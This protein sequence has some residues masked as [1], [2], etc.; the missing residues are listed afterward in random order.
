M[1]NLDNVSVVRA[2]ETGLITASELDGLT[3]LMRNPKVCCLKEV[4][5]YDSNQYDIIEVSFLESSMP[6]LL[7]AFVHTREVPRRWR[8]QGVLEHKIARHSIRS[9]IWCVCMIE[10]NV[11][12]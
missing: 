7:F 6:S 11:S 9:V 3:V 10:A 8:Q 4:R 1:A 12:C 5:R 2:L